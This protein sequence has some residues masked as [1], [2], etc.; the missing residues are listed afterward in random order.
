M[1]VCAVQKLA[2]STFFLFLILSSVAVNCQAP[3]DLSGSDDDTTENL[4]LSKDNKG[5]D[6]LYERT[7]RAPRKR[8]GRLTKIADKDRD[9]V[10]DDDSLSDGSK[11][12]GKDH[13]DQ[14][15]QKKLKDLQDEKD[16]SRKS[17]VKTLSLLRETLKQLKIEIHQY[18]TG[19]VL[20][21]DGGVTE[22]QKYQ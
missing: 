3:G 11:E 12:D 17:F 6:A 4:G 13:D 19:R 15:D 10:T 14:E 21:S 9:E 2:L 18:D 22:A 1:K 8:P 20:R 16:R 5:S 7:R